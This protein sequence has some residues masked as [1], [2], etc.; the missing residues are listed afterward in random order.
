MAAL[1]A[2]LVLAIGAAV[3]SGLEAQRLRDPGG[4]V[5]L[6][7]EAATREVAEQVSAGLKAIFSYDYNNLA[8]TE[9]A[10]D[11]VLVGRAVEQYARSFAD[12]KARAQEQ[13]LVRTTTVRS[14]GVQELAGSEAR[15]VV[16]VDQQTLH[17]AEDNR[18]DTTTAALT[19]A[20]TRAGGSWKLSSLTPL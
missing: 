5:A 20:A 4:N 13:R 1:V 19:V 8:R 17:T 18:Q 10:A 7:D 11:D 2:V 9:R 6:A 14:V 3:W 12:A 15:V 16:L